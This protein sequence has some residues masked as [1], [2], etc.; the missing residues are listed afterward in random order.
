MVDPAQPRANL[1]RQV[2]QRFCI[3][4]LCV[5]APYTTALPFG[6]VGIREATHTRPRKSLLC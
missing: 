4:Y 6:T 2:I 1:L 3:E 5:A